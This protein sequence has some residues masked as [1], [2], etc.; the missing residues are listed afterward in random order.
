MPDVIDSRTIPDVR[1]NTRRWNISRRQNKS[2]R[3]N[4]H[5]ISQPARDIRT[6][7]D[8]IK[9]ARPTSGPGLKPDL[10]QT[11]SRSIGHQA[12]RQKRAYR[13]EPRPASLSFGHRV[14]SSVS[15]SGTTWCDPQSR[16]AHEARWARTSHCQNPAINPPS[17]DS[18]LVSLP[19]SN[20]KQPSFQVLLCPRQCKKA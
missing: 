11:E 12:C 4:Q 18:S 17:K 15:V 2:R 5:A 9:D 1:N 8:I 6:M 10:H 20:H 16:W 7:P 13:H 14:V 19:E 3:Q